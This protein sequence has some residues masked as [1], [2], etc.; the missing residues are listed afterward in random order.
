[1]FTYSFQVGPGQVS[2]L[3]NL[4]LKPRAGCVSLAVGL[5]L[6]D[7]ALEVPQKLVRA[8]VTITGSAWQVRGIS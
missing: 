4:T 7:A 5:E 6:A 2:G 3:S 1:M 8:Q